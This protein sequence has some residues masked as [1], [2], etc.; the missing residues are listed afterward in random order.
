[1]EDRAI[2][3][4]GRGQVDLVLQTNILRLIYGGVNREGKVGMQS[5]GDLGLE[6]EGDVR[7]GRVDVVGVFVDGFSDDV[8]ATLVNDQDV[9][10]RLRP[11]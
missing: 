6:D 8:G 3:A 9:A 1:M 7:I 4:E 2:A 11:L 10:R 5:F